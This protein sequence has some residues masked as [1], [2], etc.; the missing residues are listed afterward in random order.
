MLGM[1]ILVSSMLI[2][3]CLFVLSR[4]RVLLAEVVVVIWVFCFLSSCCRYFSIFGWFFMVSR[5]RFLSGKGLMICLLIGLLNIL[6]SGCL[7]VCGW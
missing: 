5:C 2:V 4:V 3:V 6:C 1:L 7:L